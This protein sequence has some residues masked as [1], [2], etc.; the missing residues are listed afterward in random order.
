MPNK[1]SYCET[2]YLVSINKPADIYNLRLLCQYWDTCLDM[3]R[4]NLGLVTYGT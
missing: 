2:L 1:M 3:K 4:G